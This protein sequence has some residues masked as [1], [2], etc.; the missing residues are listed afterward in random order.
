MRIQLMT[1]PGLVNPDDDPNY[2]YLFLFQIRP[3]FYANSNEEAD[4]RITGRYVATFY[5]KFY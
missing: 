1:K 2:F 5:Q 4:G 3:V